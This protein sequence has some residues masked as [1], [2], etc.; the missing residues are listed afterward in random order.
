MVTLH[1]YTPTNHTTTNYLQDLAS[2]LAQVLNDG[3]ATYVYGH[4]RL[5]AQAGGSAT[6]YAYD[7]LGSLRQTLD[8]SGAALAGANYDPWG[9]PQGAAVAPFGFT[10]ELQDGAGQVYLRARWYT[11]SSGVF[12]SRDPFSGDT[13][14]PETLHPYS[15]VGGNPVNGTDPSG[16]C[17]P[18][19]T[20]LRQ[21]E[22]T[23]CSN[24]DQAGRIWHHP[25]SN[26]QQKGLALGYVT[27]WSTG[28]VC[29]LVGAAILAEAAAVAG[30]TAVLAWLQR[31]ATQASVNITPATTTAERGANRVEQVVKFFG[32]QVVETGRQVKILGIGSTDIDVVLTG[33]R[34]IEVGGPAKGF[35]PDQLSK[36]GTQLRTLA[37]YAEQEG[38]EAFFYYTK[39]TPQAAL[40]V[41]ARWVGQANVIEI[42]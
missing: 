9:M 7:G 19:L 11:P 13:T 27:V 1:A 31:N 15:Y 5:A 18:P 10:G 2:P 21:L 24:L 39:G 28:H 17:F 42:P 23:N 34:F 6:W 37:A 41:A 38:G 26:L 25:N 29:A 36:F 30:T 14:R 3:T 4:A 12:T 32:S 35:T 40:N 20:Y 22:P 16:K 33:K 8:G